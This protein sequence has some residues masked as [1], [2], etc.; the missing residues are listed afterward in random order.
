MSEEFSRLV[1]VMDELREKCP[2]DQEQT[3]QSLVKYLV[4]ETYELVDAIETDDLVSMREELGDLLLQVIFHARIASE[5]NAFTINDVAHD[6]AEKLIR[7]HPHVFSD[8]SA[9][10]AQEVEQNWESLKAAEKQRKSVIDGIAMSQPSLA[11]TSAVIERSRKRGIDLQIDRMPLPDGVDDQMIGNLLL[12]VVAAAQEH[13][14]DAEQAL[15]SAGRALL[16]RVRDGEGSV[17]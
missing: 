3:H 10:S 17:G 4:E 15:R 5:S 1:Q 6:I 14:V 7:R 12:R 11:W 9:S 13:G 8:A 2:W 16:S